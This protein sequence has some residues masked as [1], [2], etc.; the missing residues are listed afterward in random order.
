MVWSSSLAFNL[1]HGR[2]LPASAARSLFFLLPYGIREENNNKKIG[3]LLSSSSFEYVRVWNERESGE[4]RME[5]LYMYF[6]AVT[7]QRKTFPFPG[8]DPLH[9]SD[10]FCLQTKNS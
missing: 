7:Y 3:E 5:L 2:K 9:I 6:L 4:W 10:G 8:F 1:L